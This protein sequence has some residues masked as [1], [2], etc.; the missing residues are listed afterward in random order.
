[1]DDRRTFKAGCTITNIRK[2]VGKREKVVYADLVAVS[3]THLGK[4]SPPHWRRTGYRD[5]C[6]ERRL[7]R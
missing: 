3:Y 6:S 7:A 5:R 2:G 4:R 1:M